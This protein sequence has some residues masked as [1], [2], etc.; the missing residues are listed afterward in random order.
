MTGNLVFGWNIWIQ[1]LGFLM[2]MT[3]ALAEANRLPFDLPEC[4]QELVG[5]YHTEYSAMKFALFMLAEYIHMITVSFILAVV[6][7]GG[8]HFPLIAEAT[9]SYPFSWLVK[10]GV[11]LTKVAVFVLF[12]MFIR[13]TIPRFRFDQL[14]GLAWRVLIPLSIANFAAVL[15]VKHWNVPTAILLP[16]SLAIFL[17]SGLIHA[18]GVQHRL[19]A[20]RI[21]DR[22]APARG[23]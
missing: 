3:A 16:I 23:G 11:L 2:F 9:S 1:P 20:A 22:L 6:F 21:P 5:G 18:R 4:E 17:G 19:S 7:F 10:I 8:W 15:F 14:M 13:W 12:F